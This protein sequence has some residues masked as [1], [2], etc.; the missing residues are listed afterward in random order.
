MITADLI[1]KNAICLLPDSTETNLIQTKCDVVIKDQKILHLGDSK[2]YSAPQVQDLSGLVLSA[3]LIDSQVHFREPGL[4]HK[5]DLES[6]TLAA[7]FGGITAIFEMPNTSP[8]TISHDLFKQKLDRAAEV[9]Y[10]HYA[11]YL[12][13][14]AQNLSELPSLEKLPHC[15][16]IKI[17]MGSSTGSLLVDSDQ[18]LEEIVKTTR[19][20]LVIHSE[21][22]KRL[23]AR[24][25]IAIDS[26]SPTA[27][28]LWRDVESALISTKKIVALAEKYQHRIHVLHISSQEEMEFLKNHKSYVSVEVL[29]QH[30]TLFAPNCYEEFGTLAQQNPPIREEKHL[31][32]LWKGVLDSTVDVMGSDHAP[33]TLEEKALPYPQSPSG[34]PGVQTMVPIMLQ[35]VFEG[36][37]T[38]EKMVALLTLGPRRIFKIKNKGILKIGADADLT[39]FDLNKK[40]TLDNAQMKS[41][42]AW[43][44]FHGKT[45]HGA[46]HSV[47]LCGEKVF[48]Q[49]QVLKPHRGRP[50]DFEL[51]FV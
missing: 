46:I 50:V 29:P 8:P 18:V 28:P 11:F 24:K 21:D 4:I 36:Q 2:N 42:S 1:L 41:K 22:E 37:I 19:H 32:G 44:P 17:F 13:A 20:L 47:Y 30:L 49:G 38:L 3:G 7:L 34:M 40:W 27:H 45:I 10:T 16:G 48:E 39:I 23:K 15:P 43:T 6:G 51:N 25:Q 33:H 5:E 31:Q 9:A 12:G 26:G 14:S 35:H